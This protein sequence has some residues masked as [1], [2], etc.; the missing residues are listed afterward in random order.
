MSRSL[1][2]AR[3]RALSFSS[4]LSPHIPL[5]ITITHITAKATASDL[6]DGGNGQRVGGGCNQGGIDMKPTILLFGVDVLD[7]EVE[8]ARPVAV[9]HRCQRQHGGVSLQH[10][11]WDSAEV[12]NRGHSV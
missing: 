11:Q 6:D 3:A 1:S 5:P 7:F 4:S 12:M 2:L 9:S 8:R 10:E